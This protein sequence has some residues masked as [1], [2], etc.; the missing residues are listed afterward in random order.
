MQAATSPLV[1]VILRRAEREWDWID[2]APSLR[3]Y[4]ETKRRI[5]WIASEQ[6]Q[7]LLLP[8]PDHQ[9][10]LVTFALATGLRHGKVI[11]LECRTSISNVRW[12]GFTA[13][14]LWPDAIFTSHS[15]TPRWK[16]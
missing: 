5:R 11:L 10:E 12:L 9:R 16:Y 7:K 8:L 1:R 3:M 2:R 4:P 13:I 15:M 6:V 14:R